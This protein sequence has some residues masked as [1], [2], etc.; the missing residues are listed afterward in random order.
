MNGDVLTDLDY[1]GC[2][3]ITAERCRRDDRDPRERDPDLARRAALRDEADPTRVTDYVEKPHI[4]Y[5]V[6][7]GVYCFSPERRR[8]HRARSTSISR[9]CLRLIARRLTVRA[10]RSPDYWRDIG[11][12]DDYEQ[13]LD[14]FERMRARSCRPSDCD[15]GRTRPRTRSADRVRRLQR[16]GQRRVDQPAPPDGM[17]R[18]RQPRAVRRVARVAPARPGLLA[19]IALGRIAR[20]LVAEG[21]RRV[22]LVGASDGV[23]RALAAGAAA[24]LQR[25]HPPPERKALLARGWCAARRRR[26]GL[27]R[28][29]LWGYVP[30]GEWLL[31]IARS[32]AGRLPLRR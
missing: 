12:H 21:P 23:D 10:W 6:S 27:R 30:Q 22:A 19:T 7:M 32:R 4:D 15:S 1:G 13:A 28:P 18:G 8:A 5:Q 2:S 11:R 14:D 17:A 3:K 16:L 20:R 26:L 24:S 25:D 29:V 31:K 9:T